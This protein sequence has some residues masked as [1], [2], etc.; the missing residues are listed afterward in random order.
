MQII[1]QSFNVWEHD[2]DLASIWHHIAEVAKL[3]YP[4]DVRNK[5][6]E[7]D[8]NFVERVVEKYCDTKILEHGTVYLTIPDKDGIIYNVPSMPEILKYKE[9]PY[10][11]VAIALMDDNW[12]I[13]TNM[14]VIKD[15]G[16]EQDLFDYISVP[17]IYHKRRVT[18]SFITSL[19]I[20]REFNCY[21]CH[22]I[23]YSKDKLGNELTFIKPYWFDTVPPG[24]RADYVCSIQNSELDYIN[25]IQ[26]G[27]SPQEA[28]EVLPLSTKTQVVHT[29]FID[30]WE[31]FFNLRYFGSYG[32]SHPAAKEL[33]GK[34]Y[35]MFCEKGY[36]EI[37][38]IIDEI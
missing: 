8:K 15:N 18:V 19:G 34:L 5:V 35:D 29:A 1:E 16:W 36:S 9:N 33:A 7:T 17:F 30:D 4:N 26:R 2:S 20:S 25:L 22:S 31:Q 3:V 24:I 28:R 10:S 21:R 12:Y 13:T 6:N 23:S 27:C 38:S 14:R 32:K 37:K 11:K